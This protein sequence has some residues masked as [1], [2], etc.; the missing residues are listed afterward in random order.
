MRPKCGLFGLV[1]N[2]LANGVAEQIF[3]KFK[4]ASDQK[5]LRELRAAV[6]PKCRN[7]RTRT[8]RRKSAES[9]EIA[10]RRGSIPSATQEKSER[11]QIT[12]M[13]FIVDPR[14]GEI[15]VW[16]WLVVA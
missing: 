2:G 8:K 7:K 13:D 1:L 12:E 15:S 5:P 16:P 3:P 11:E 14:L 10:G 6:Q 4:S 9:S